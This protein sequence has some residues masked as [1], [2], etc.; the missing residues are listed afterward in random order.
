MS[1]KKTKN[2]LGQ[3]KVFTSTET[4]RRAEA[5]SGIGAFEFDLASKHWVWTPQVAV[6][7]GLDPQ[8]APSQFNDWLPAVFPDDALKIR[9]ALETCKTSG[10]FYVEFRV[11]RPDGRLSWLAGK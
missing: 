7:F 10:Q 8:S 6:L 4:L 9:S 11:K 3:P 2:Q 5:A 1:E